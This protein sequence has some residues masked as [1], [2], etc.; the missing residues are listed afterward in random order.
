M[1]EKRNLRASKLAQR[2][3][4]DGET[5]ARKSG[6][7]CAKVAA[8]AAEALDRT[9]ATEREGRK[10]RV[11]VY[12]A[13]RS[14]VDLQPF[15]E[16]VY[17]RGWI[18]CFPC[19]VRDEPHAESRMAFYPVPID[20]FDGARA[21]FLDH[22]LRCLPCGEL[23]EH[24]YEEVDPAD[25]DVVVVPL[26]AFDDAGNRLGYG[27][28]NYDRLLPRLRADALVVGVAFDEQRTAAVPCEPHDRPLPHIVSA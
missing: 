26:V 14:E 11:A 19:M 15:V 3:A 5:R 4:L 27:G 10:P 2:D 22:P 25:L 12:A 16:T 1:D 6:N 13:M 28:G 23:A 9:A 8:L 7:V 24:G 18:P 21:E 17:A 20:R